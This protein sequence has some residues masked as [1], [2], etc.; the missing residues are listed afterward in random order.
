MYELPEIEMVRA[1]LTERFSGI[2]IQK[3]Y[4]NAKVLLGKRIKFLEEL[5][6]AT[7]WFVERRSG[8]LILHLDNGKRVLIEFGKETRFYGDENFKLDKATA[9]LVLYFQNKCCVFYNLEEH[10]VQLLTVREVDQ[11]LN[12]VAPDAFDKA[13][14]KQ[15]F[16]ESLAKKRSTLKNA[17]MDGKLLSAVGSIYSDE[18]LFESKLH[19]SRKAHTLTEDE[20]NTLYDAIGFVLKEASIDGGSIDSPMSSQDM[21]SGSY[22]PKHNVYN[23]EGEVCSKCNSIIEQ[24]IVAKQKCYICP[25]CQA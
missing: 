25:Q 7:I 4:I 21:F 3:V 15:Y 17:L 12:I 5:T 14:S 13:F 20:M 1:N 11:Q 16:T 8:H 19:P 18:I 24:I 22:L 9:D 10:D 2:P 23:R 6:H